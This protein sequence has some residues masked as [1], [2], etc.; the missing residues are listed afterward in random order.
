MVHDQVAF[1][2][3]L[4]SASVSKIRGWPERRG[5]LDD[6]VSR[7]ST[8]DDFPLKEL[9]SDRQPIRKA[10]SYLLLGVRMSTGRENGD[11]IIFGAS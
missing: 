6:D 8:M 1:L 11:T 2:G 5:E 4:G 9:V 3:L 10:T 7:M